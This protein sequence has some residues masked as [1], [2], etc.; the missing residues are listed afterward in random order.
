MADDTARV[1]EK[2]RHLWMPETGGALHAFT[3]PSEAV[4][5]DD[6]REVTCEA[7]KSA[8]VEAV[9]ADQQRRQAEQRNR[10]DGSDR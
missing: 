8:V 3:R 4:F 6:L 2:A 7:C 9:R 1:A 10:T 5:T